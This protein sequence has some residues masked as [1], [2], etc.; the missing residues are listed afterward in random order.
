[1]ACTLHLQ[2]ALAACTVH[3]LA[4]CTCTP[5]LTNGLSTD[6]H[7]ILLHKDA[8]E[9]DLHDF[10]S[11]KTILDSRGKNPTLTIQLAK[12]GEN[13]PNFRYYGDSS[14]ADL[15]LADPSPVDP[16]LIEIR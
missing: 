4:E 3:A 9:S 16:S 12:W 5:R 13:T 7:N 1:V 6:I 8:T 14:P 2:H 15:S 11:R 10:F